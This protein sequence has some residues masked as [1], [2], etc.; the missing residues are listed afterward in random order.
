MKNQCQHTG[1]NAVFELL[2]SRIPI[3]EILKKQRIWKKDLE[4]AT[5][6]EEGFEKRCS[7]IFLPQHKVYIL[8][9]SP[10]KEARSSKMTFPRKEARSSFSQEVPK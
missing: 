9:L 1:Q 5:N 10:R 2:F 3:R 7:F 4:K 6:L 8:E